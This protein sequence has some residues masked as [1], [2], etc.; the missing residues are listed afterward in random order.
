MVASVLKMWT[1]SFLLEENKETH[2]IPEVSRG[3]KYSW[4]LTEADDTTDT[5]LSNAYTGQNKAIKLF[6]FF[7]LIQTNTRE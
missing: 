3:G 7:F 5:S 4:P 2:L 1:R 6:I